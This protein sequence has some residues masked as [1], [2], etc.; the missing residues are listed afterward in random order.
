MARA[1]MRTAIISSRTSWILCELA[2]AG[3]IASSAIA[4]EAPFQSR[5]VTPAG[6]YTFG[7]EGAAGD[8]KGNLYVVNFGKTGTIGKLAVDAS[9]AELFASL[10]QGSARTASRY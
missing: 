3:L 2:V 10:P 4:Q 8:A 1:R 9:P 6:E 7:L 5:Q